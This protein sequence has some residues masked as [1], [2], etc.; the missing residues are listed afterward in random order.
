MD[1]VRA[2]IF[3]FGRVQGVFFRSHAKE[4][5]QSFGLVGWV[6][7]NPD[8]TVEI[9]AEGSK[10]KLEGFIKWCREGPL[11]AKVEKT[12]VEWEKANR[13]FDSFEILYE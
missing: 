7:N 10:E 9:L 2:H 6:R 12:E 11:F 5:A 13:E 3:I 1:R 8:G 4:T